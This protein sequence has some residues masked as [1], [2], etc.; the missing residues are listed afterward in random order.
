MQAY[1]RGG[2]VRPLET[3]ERAVLSPV[4]TAAMVLAKAARPQKGRAEE[5]QAGGG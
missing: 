1:E 4:A 5:G 2:G 3:R